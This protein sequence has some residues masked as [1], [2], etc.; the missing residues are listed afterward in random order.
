M[1]GSFWIID[2]IHKMKISLESSEQV[3]LVLSNL[4]KKANKFHAICFEWNSQ[5]GYQ[6]SGLE[7]NRIH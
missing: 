3:L 4:I 7:E 1:F 6:P 2:F 5:V